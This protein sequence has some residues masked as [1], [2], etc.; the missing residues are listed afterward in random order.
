MAFDGASKKKG[1]WVSKAIRK[2]GALHEELGIPMGEKI[3]T[4][5]LDKAAKAGG[6]LGQR[7]RLAK[8]MR[9]F[10]HG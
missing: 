2:P 4:E 8:T 1:G 3:P 6:K 5:T 9:G 7:A 10:K